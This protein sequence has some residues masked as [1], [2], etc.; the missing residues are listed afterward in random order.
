MRWLDGITDSMDTNVSKLREPVKDRGDWCAEVHGVA[1]NQTWLN[2]WTIATT[3]PYRL[4]FCGKDLISARV[5]S[6]RFIHWLAHWWQLSDAW[7]LSLFCAVPT[8]GQAASSQ[9]KG[10]ERESPWGQKREAQ[11]PKLP[12]CALKC[13]L[14]SH[15]WLSATPCYLVHGILQAGILEWVAVPFSRGS[16]QPRD[17][18]QVSHFAGG[19]FT[20]WVMREAQEYWNG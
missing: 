11:I 3:L 6:V 9:G 12:G 20:S 18:T 1:K 13:K 7:M 8:G 2:T 4:D 14:L 15:V 19:F 10:D 17:W 5:I 16:S